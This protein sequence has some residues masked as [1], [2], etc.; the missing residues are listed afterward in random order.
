[1][2]GF[3]RFLLRYVT[4]IKLLVCSRSCIPVVIKN[5]KLFKRYSILCFEKLSINNDSD[6]IILLFNSKI[7]SFVAI[8]F[9][10][11]SSNCFFIF[12]FCSRDFLFFT[13]LIIIFLIN[14]YY[15]YQRDYLL[16]HQYSFF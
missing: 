2:S 12:C 16:R 8:I 10:Y 14:S 3:T 7:S 11:S 1:M 5:S 13:L 6:L 15:Y 9:L 4:P